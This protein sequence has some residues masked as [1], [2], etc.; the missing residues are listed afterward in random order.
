LQI[1]IATCA[2]NAQIAAT[3]FLWFLQKKAALYGPDSKKIVDKARVAM[4]LLIAESKP[5]GKNLLSKV[6]VHLLHSEN[7]KIN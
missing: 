6:L 5:G 7:L 4:D 1:S 3:L 2:K